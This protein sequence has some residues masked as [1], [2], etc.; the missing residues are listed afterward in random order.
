MKYF[1]LF[2]LFLAGFLIPWHSTNASVLKIAS[3][4]TELGLKQEFLVVVSMDTQGE[5]VNAIEGTIQFPDSAL[6][7]KGIREQGSIVSLWIKEPEAKDG[8]ISFSALIPGGY[9]GEGVLFSLV[10]QATKEG[11]SLI[12]FNK[13]RVLLHDGKGTESTISFVSLPIVISQELESGKGVVL[14]YDRESPEPFQLQITQDPAERHFLVF[15]AKDKNSGIDHF[16]ISLLVNGETTKWQRAENPFVLERYKDIEKIWVKAVDR[17][18][19]EKIITLQLQNPL[20][21]YLL[22]GSFATIIGIGIIGAGVL[23]KKRRKARAYS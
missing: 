20:F 7:L 14:Q 18:G 19:N 6:V 12:D 13:G 15:A 2:F 16:E 3:E 23:L 22:L 5:T 8:N 17:A 1:L 21:R 4:A 9:Q 11:E 10:F